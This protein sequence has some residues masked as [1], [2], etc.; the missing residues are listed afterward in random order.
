MKNYLHHTHVITWQK[1]CMTIF[2]AL[3]MQFFKMKSFDST[4]T[5]SSSYLCQIHMFRVLLTYVGIDQI[6]RHSLQCVCVKLFA[7][8][9]LPQAQA[10][11]GFLEQK[12]DRFVA[13]LNFNEPCFS[14][15]RTVH[16]L[17][18]KKWILLM[19]PISTCSKS[20]SNSVKFACWMFGLICV[21]R[22]M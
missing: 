6:F 19:F 17:S 3:S 11:V 15:K 18:F 13:K 14:L 1:A 16:S 21:C 12:M 22:W 5:W 10:L 2:L 9:T 4:L 20:S 8:G 7:H